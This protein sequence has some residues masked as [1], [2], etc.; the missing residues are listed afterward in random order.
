MAVYLSKMAA[1]MVGTITSIGRFF[2]GYEMEAFER[3]D[4]RLGRTRL[5]SSQPHRS[6][7]SVC[8]MDMHVKFYILEY[9]FKPVVTTY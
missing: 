1:T 2:P 8:C 9:R 3:T 5:L 7:Q 6:M 4:H